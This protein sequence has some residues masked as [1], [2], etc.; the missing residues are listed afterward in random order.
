MKS[1]V[2]VSPPGEFQRDDIYSV[3]RW[4]RVQ[5]LVNQFW[6]RWR[7]EYVQNLQSRSKWLKP[8][9]DLRIGDIV[10]IK[11]ELL[12]RNGWRLGRVSEVK[13]SADSHVR[14]VFLIVGDRDLDKYG[15]RVNKVVRLERP[16]HKLVLLI[17]S[18]C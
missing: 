9:R 10:V 13:R 3:K 17:P 14:S 4:R 5:Y 2:I 11:D 7:S 6:S 16:V 15:K 12:H 8:Q 1:K 18:D